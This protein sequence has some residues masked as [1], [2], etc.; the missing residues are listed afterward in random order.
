MIMIVY[1]CLP[2]CLI[3]VSFVI[4]LFFFSSRR[5]H[6]RCALVTG[7]QT[8]ALPIYGRSLKVHEAET[9][10]WRERR[11]HPCHGRGAT[12]GGRPFSTI[13]AE[14][15]P[16]SFRLSRTAAP[17]P[18]VE[19]FRGPGWVDSGRAGSNTFTTAPNLM[20]E[21]TDGYVDE[22]PGQDR[23]TARG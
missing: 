17:I 16:L 7:V 8:C 21:C 14:S 3:C 9:G 18:N 6:T 15:E 19:Q 12:R 2:I 10:P 1:L 13:L 22:R 20:A 11:D 5:R 23:K 4:L